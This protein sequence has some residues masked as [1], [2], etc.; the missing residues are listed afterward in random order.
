MISGSA[1]KDLMT[2]TTTKLIITSMMSTYMIIINKDCSCDVD[3]D[4]DRY[5]V[6]TQDRALEENV[7]H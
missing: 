1:G 7:T 5:Y 2:T 6:R 3:V 4:D